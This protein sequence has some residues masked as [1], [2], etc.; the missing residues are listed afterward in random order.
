MVDQRQRGID[1]APERRQMRAVLIV[2]AL[3]LRELMCVSRCRQHEAVKEPAQHLL[4]AVEVTLTA[5]ILPEVAALPEANVT[6]GKALQ[7]HE[8]KLYLR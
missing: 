8:R 3:D 5:A 6:F 2:P 1:G 7:C 4:R